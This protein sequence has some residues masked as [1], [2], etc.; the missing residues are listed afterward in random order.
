MPAAQAHLRSRV[1][2]LGGRRP[3]LRVIHVNGIA[4]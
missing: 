3:E 1:F 2:Q 4:V